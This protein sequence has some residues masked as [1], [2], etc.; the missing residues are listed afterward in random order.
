MEIGLFMHS[1]NMPDTKQETKTFMFLDLTFGEFE[2]IV[3]LN[4]FIQ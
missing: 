4:N 1:A 2:A 3:V